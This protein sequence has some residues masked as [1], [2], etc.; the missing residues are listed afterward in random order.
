MRNSRVKCNVILPLVSSRSSQVSIGSVEQALTE[1]QSAVANLIGVQPKSNL[2]NLLYDVRLLLLRMAY[3]E[4]LNEDCGGGS[5]MS[6]SKL[7]FYQ[8]SMHSG[9]GCV[10]SQVI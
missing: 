10:R 4:L 7:I 8:L 3:G 6:N 1:H 9:S 2:W 5:L